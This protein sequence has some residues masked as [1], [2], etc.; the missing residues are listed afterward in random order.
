MNTIA[1]MEA[2]ATRPDLIPAEVHG[3]VVFLIALAG[4]VLWAGVRYLTTRH[5]ERLPWYGVVGSRV[6]SAISASWCGLQLLAR[7][8]EL[9]G[10]WPL[11]LAA[12]I[13]G[14]AVEG[15]AALYRHERGV[16]NRRLGLVLVVLRG[17]AILILVV[18]LLQ[19]VR[20]WSAVRN[21]S[22]R[23]VVLLDDSGSM[24][25]TDRKW[26]PSEKVELA[27]QANLIK[28][29]ERPMP[30][31]DGLL[32]WPATLQPWT[33]MM[34]QTNA[35]P[36]ALVELLEHKASQ[37]RDL[38]EAMDGYQGS[39]DA[40]K[41]RKAG[42]AVER[43]Q[44][45]LRET[46][47]PALS[48]AQKASGDQRLDSNHLRRVSEAAERVASTVNAT[49]AAIDDLAWQDLPDARREAINSY[50]TTTRVALA[51]AVL[52]Q[53]P[54]G[55]SSLLD[56]LSERYDIDLLRMG[57]GLES[58][59][60]KSR[61]GN[62]WKPVAGQEAFR[63]LSDYTLALEKVLKE[64]PSEELAG[65]LMLSD[66]R[67][68]SV[69]SL[70]PI[71][72]RLGLQGVPVCGVVV[73]ST[74]VPRDV[75]IGEVTAPESIFLG[76]KVR[77]RV[78]LHV[79]GA[80][81]K[82]VH[83]R[84][85]GPASAGAVVTNAPPSGEGILDQGYLDVFTDDYT[86]EI[87][88]THEPKEHGIFSYTLQA[89][90]LEGELFSTNN[91]W[92]VDVAVSDDRT[93][94]LLIDERPRWEFRYLRNLFYGRDKS[95]HLQYMLMHPDQAG[96]VKAKAFP[97]ASAS[98]KFGDAESGSLPISRE[99]WRKF[100]LIILGDLSPDSLSEDVIEEIRKC[101]SERG[102]M[103][104]VSVG[105]NDM[106]QS[107]D[108]EALMELL[109][110]RYEPRAGEGLSVES[111]LGSKLVL[112]VA[113]KSHPVMQQSDSYSENEAVWE[114]MPEIGWH[115]PLLDVKPG[116]EVLAYAETV[117]GEEVESG[118]SDAATRL[119][120]ETRNRSRNALVVAQTYGRGKVLMLNFDQTW[121]LRY[122]AGDTYHH[123]FWGQIMRWGVGEKLRAGEDHLRVGTDQLIYTPGQSPRVLARV[124]DEEAMGIVNAQLDVS[125]N[126]G[127][128]E[129][130]RVRPVYRE[131]SHGMYEVELPPCEEPGRY[132]LRLT[133][134]DGERAQEVDTAFVVVTAARSIELA[135]VTAT[136]KDLQT[137]SRLTGGRVVGPARAA[138]LWNA[139]GE[140]RTEV[141]E[142]HERSMWDQPWVLIFLIGLLSTE[143]LLRKKGG[144]T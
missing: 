30:E 86:R 39:L 99:E 1:I 117:G 24:N 124:T 29:D 67:N 17:L 85:S 43:L 95:V 83:L 123:R 51:H 37:A 97:P 33:A 13:A 73:G 23:V 34:T 118:V 32:D 90:V 20:V 4:L 38:L 52:T 137:L 8:C 142:R 81:G 53:A 49:R 48:E 91:T 101:V 111:T 75:A 46:L 36:P 58:M 12:V 28:V 19:P 77:V 21:I 72:R 114:E 138:T 119:D 128:R 25:F 60:A 113:G 54:E 92:K 102:A 130:A 7:G 11:W 63:S 31:L 121:R 26:T 141:Q 100:D 16:I 42:Y 87:L 107:F 74:G 55:Q 139:F 127:D 109:P 2:G 78:K 110:V 94:V 71:G 70:D 143:W 50:C 105:R 89:D 122:K 132:D 68:N 108:S 131:G 10:P 64:T 104:V 79:T 80:K 106:P 56:R 35:P 5:Q 41:G 57:N 116:A 120:E 76:D 45:Q 115:L 47:V 129:V 103:L 59:D 144:L 22:R 84:M 82:R 62:A 44:G 69:M 18:V 40:E 88:L 134:K 126:L 27:L 65:V 9:T 66:G 140:G 96:G 6:L 135:S 93:N 112:T 136:R 15:A 133:R 61:S 14:L 125:V 3:F 98:R